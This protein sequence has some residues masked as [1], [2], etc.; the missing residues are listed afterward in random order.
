[1]RSKQGGTGNKA[2]LFGEAA[3][4]GMQLPSGNERR[5]SSCRANDYSGMILISVPAGGG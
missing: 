1:M 5:C 3:L 4:A 2:D